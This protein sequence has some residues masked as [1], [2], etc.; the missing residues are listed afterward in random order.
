MDLNFFSQNG[1]KLSEK[2]ESIIEKNISQKKHCVIERN[3]DSINITESYIKY[4]LKLFPEGFL[5][6]D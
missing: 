2:Q 4:I 3:V 5:R 1:T 6:Q